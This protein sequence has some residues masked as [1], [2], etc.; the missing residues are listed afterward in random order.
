VKQAFFS[1]SLDNYI[2]SEGG[3]S[4][5]VLQYSLVVQFST[6]KM[7]AHDCQDV[8]ILA[9]LTL[10]AMTRLGLVPIASTRSTSTIMIM[11]KYEVI[12][13]HNIQDWD[14]RTSDGVED[15]N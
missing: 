5:T 2:M 10:A 9:R 15:A 8:I 7:T 12:T 1:F 14:Q 11:S 6:V 3:I 4:T 13:E